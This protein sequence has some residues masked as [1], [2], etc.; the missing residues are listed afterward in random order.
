M[1]SVEKLTRGLNASITAKEIRDTYAEYF[2]NEGAIQ[3]Q[4]EKY[5]MKTITDT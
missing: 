2:I 5:W 4:W 1:F 3:W